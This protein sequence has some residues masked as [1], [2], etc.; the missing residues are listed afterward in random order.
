MSTVEASDVPGGVLRILPAPPENSPDTPQSDTPQTPPAEPVEPAASSAEP[1]DDAQPVFDM[2]DVPLGTLL[3][4]SGLVTAEQ[5]GSALAEGSRTRQRLGEVLVERGWLD[6]ADLARLLAGQKGLSYVDLETTQIDPEA[7]KLWDEDTARAR[8]AIAIGFADGSAVVAISDPS[9]DGVVAF[10]DEH[11]GGSYTLAV[12]PRTEIDRVLS[13]GAQPAVEA[14]PARPAPTVVPAPVIPIHPV[15]MPQTEMRL[16]MEPPPTA[17]PPP[18]PDPPPVETA[19]AASFSVVM[20]LVNGEKIELFAS[21]DRAA[22]QAGAEDVVRQL[23]ATEAAGW[24]AIGGRF[25]RPAAIVSI[26]VVEAYSA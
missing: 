4:R 25:V 10:L 26:D 16:P 1:Q 24:P 11:L 2:R 23:V 17:V 9:D 6:D 18:T 3:H 7:L 22:A 14:A 13:G 5:L 21:N 12:A 20:S 15:L 19:R 8:G